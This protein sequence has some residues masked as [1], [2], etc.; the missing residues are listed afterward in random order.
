MHRQH[1][2]DQAGDAGEGACQGQ[3]THAEFFRPVVVVPGV[4]FV[5]GLAILAM[6]LVTWHN[7]TYYQQL[8]ADL[9]AAIE[10]GTFEAYVAQ[11]NAL[12]EEGDI[13]PL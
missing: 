7:L 9:R 11:F 8:M 4:A 12:Q 10:G 2:L 13:E 3:V 6:M 5:G 1:R